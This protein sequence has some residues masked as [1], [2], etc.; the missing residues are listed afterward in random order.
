M[1]F[2]GLLSRPRLRSRLAEPS[3]LEV[4]FPPQVRYSTSLRVGLCIELNDLGSRPQS[5]SHSLPSQTY[6]GKRTSAAAHG[7]V[8]VVTMADFG[9]GT[10]IIEDLSGN[11]TDADSKLEDGPSGKPG[12]GDDLSV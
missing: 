2:D 8:S 7:A 4:G 9:T 12:G 5:N 6:E 10:Q 1:I 11:G 3:E